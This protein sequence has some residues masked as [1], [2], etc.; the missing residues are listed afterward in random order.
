MSNLN[1]AT[2]GKYFT[3]KERVKLV[4]ALQLRILAE[5]PNKDTKKDEES[6]LSVST[7][8]EIHEIVNS[9][10]QRQASDYNFYV[11]LKQYVWEHIVDEIREHVLAIELMNGNIAPLRYLLSISPY[12]SEIVS[13]L[14]RL[15]VI[16]QKE[17]Y[18]KAIVDARIHERSEIL[19]LDG[20][21][22]LAKQEAYYRLIGEKLI[23]TPEYE[24]YRDYMVVFGRSKDELFQEKVQSIRKDIDK[25][26]K[27]KDRMGG[28]APFNNYIEPYIGLSDK[29]IIE[30]VEKDYQGYFDIP[31]KEEH[32][33]WVSLVDEERKRIQHAVDIGA[34]VKKKNGIESG[35]Y[36]DWKDRR[37]K[38]AGDPGVGDRHWNPLHE[39][40]M[41]I[42]FSDGKVT[43]GARAKKGDW[44]QIIAVTVH[45]KNSMGYAGDDF[46]TK[47]LE[48]VIDM[49]S[50]LVPLDVS[51]KDFDSEE[52]RFS[53]RVGDYKAM[54]QKF[55]NNTRREI[56]EIVNKIALI[57]AIEDIYF[58]GMQIVVP[59]EIDGVLTVD[60]MLHH[61]MNV[62]SEHNDAIRDMIISFNKLSFGFWDYRLD[63]KDSY[64]IDASPGVDEKWVYTELEQVKLK[65]LSR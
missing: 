39:D 50:A 7:R 31:G 4:I 11:D 30:K 33:R 46:G 22:D 6:T 34:L 15:P 23:D 2:T 29:E 37:Q 13:E 32:D 42:G 25:Y 9:C 27:R 61:A 35:S 18:D 52:R 41:E 57:N 17:E 26:Q 43:S 65:L 38:F 12:L 60:K 53:I 40:C 56:Q 19:P 48:S 14:K 64:L 16:V 44:R 59:G 54:F 51:D 45:N 63:D 8:R 24:S 55:A 20:A 62:I 1:L 28:E 10:P 47:R 5:K 58:D 21:Y 36:Y 3:P 49:V